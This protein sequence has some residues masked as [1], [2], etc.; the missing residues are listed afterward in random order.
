MGAF[1]SMLKSVLTGLQGVENYLDDVIVAGK[2]KQEHDERL[3]AVLT[4]LKEKGFKLNAE[5]CVIGSES[6]DYL[7]HTID[8]NGIRPSQKRID[9]L[10][11]I[12]SSKII[13]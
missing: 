2:T 13:Q 7:A 10:Y 5:K 3:N 1:Q 12:S 11:K 4:R 6:M 8:K 9:A